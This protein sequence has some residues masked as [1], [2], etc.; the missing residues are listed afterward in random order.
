VEL[1][2]RHK[3][4]LISLNDLIPENLEQGDDSEEGKS[5]RSQVSNLVINAAV[6]SAVALKKSPIPGKFFFI[7]F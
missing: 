2:E 1:K 6:M 7:V 5:L 3:L 4:D